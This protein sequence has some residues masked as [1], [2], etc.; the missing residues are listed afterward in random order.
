MASMQ[1]CITNC[2]ECHSVCLSTIP[3]CLSKGGEH[4]AAGHIRILQDCAEICM[5]SADF[6]LRRSPLH[7]MICRICAGVCEICADDCTK[8]ADDEQMVL[9]IETCRRCA[10]SCAEMSG[11]ERKAA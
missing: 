8:M 1:D 7:P 4:T 6:M 5:T 3:H 2:L 9:C 11:A 10:A